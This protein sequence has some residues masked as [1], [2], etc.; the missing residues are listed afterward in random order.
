M[1]IF[2]S[3]SLHGTVNLGWLWKLL[4]LSCMH[5]VSYAIG[6]FCVNCNHD[7]GV[8][9]VNP[10]R[11]PAHLSGAVVANGF[12]KS[13]HQG[14]ASKDGQKELTTEQKAARL[15]KTRKRNARQRNKRARIQAMRRNAHA[16][17]MSPEKPAVDPL[18]DFG[19]LRLGAEHQEKKV[20]APEVTAIM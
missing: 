5:P 7:F 14:G 2:G 20:G 4:H 19:A 11:K 3:L 12:G 9:S 17:Q 15:L 18:P 10:V 13:I 6:R 8:S 16:E 1:A